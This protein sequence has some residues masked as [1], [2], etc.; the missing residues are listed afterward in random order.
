[1][2][3]LEQNNKFLQGHLPVVFF[4]TAAPIIIIMLVNGSFSLIDAYFLGVF[5][6]PEALTAITSMFPLFML[7]VA[8]STLVASGF[9]SVMARVLGAAEKQKVEAV[10]SQ[11]ITLSLVVCSVLILLFLL[12]GSVLVSTVTAGSDVLFQMSYSY[13]SIIVLFSPLMFI[14]SIN[15]DCLRCEGQIAFISLTSLVSVLLNVVFNYVLIVT[16][17]FGVV[18]SAYGTVLA[19]AFS[20][21]SIFVYRKYKQNIIALSVVSITLKRNNWVDFLK[22]G[23]PSSLYFLGLSLTSAAILY[24]LQV[25]SASNYELTVA[26]YG[27]ITRLMTFVYLPLLGLSMAFQTILGNNVG[28]KEWSRS[29]TSIKIALSASLIYCVSFQIIILFFKNDMGMLF[30]DDEMIGKE[31]GRILPITTFALFL[32]G[33]LMMVNMLFQ[34]IGDAKRA[35]I[36]GLMKTY[37][38]SLPLIFI[39]PLIFSEWGVWYAAPTTEFLALLLTFIVLYSRKSESRLGLFFK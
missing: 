38:F 14:L 8:L 11:G 12:G 33:P 18:G 16:F 22:I 7:I 23:G 25:C 20:L 6:G 24:N 1:M 9:S 39:L 36:L 27:I 15:G 10:F 28:A 21:I 17:E 31:V 5:V 29:N 35:S 30:V 3:T 32:L 2:N 34:A 26:A 4:K 13:V 19:Q 37:C